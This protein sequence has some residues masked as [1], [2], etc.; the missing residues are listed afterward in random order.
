MYWIHIKFWPLWKIDT[1]LYRE[2]LLSV[3]YFLFHIRFCHSLYS[4]EP[5]PQCRGL[6][7]QSKVITSAQI[8]GFWLYIP[9]DDLHV[10][11][12]HAWR[13]DYFPSWLFDLSGGHLWKINGPQIMS[14]KKIPSNCT[15]MKS[16]WTSKCV[17]MK[18]NCPQILTFYCHKCPRAFLKK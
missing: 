2:M 13:G 11:L 6:P 14:L 9:V 17:I 1:M 5:V 10:C 15:I 4:L 12:C 8:P 16:L 7:I 18:N 3:L